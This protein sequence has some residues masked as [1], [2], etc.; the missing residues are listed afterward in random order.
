MYWL[1]L[2]EAEIRKLH[3]RGEKVRPELLAWA[4]VEV[5]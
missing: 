3:R 5:K 1:V 4:R 2:V